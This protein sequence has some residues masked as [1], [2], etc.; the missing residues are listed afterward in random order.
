VKCGYDEGI[1][2]QGIARK[3][4]LIVENAKLKERLARLEARAA[5]APLPSL[6]GRDAL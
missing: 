3:D 6:L 1:L 2:T 5:A 4:A